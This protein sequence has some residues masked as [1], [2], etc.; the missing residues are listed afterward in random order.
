MFY[1]QKNSDLPSNFISIDEDNKTFKTN[2]WN[3]V[4][5]YF[6]DFIW[7]VYKMKEKIQ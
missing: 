4:N 7:I 2:T 6:V 5:E 3:H 1:L